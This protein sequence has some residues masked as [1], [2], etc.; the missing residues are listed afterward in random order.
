MTDFAPDL[1]RKLG[2]GPIGAPQRPDGTAPRMPRNGIAPPL[3]VPVEV[4]EQ[5]R[6]PKRL[7]VVTTRGRTK[8]GRP[9]VMMV[10]APGFAIARVIMT[11]LDPVTKQ[12]KVAVICERRR[13][14]PANSQRG[15]NGGES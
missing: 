7:K 1:A 3:Q 9:F 11:D 4:R 6:K 15:E 2:Q 12:C 8:D 14:R 5:S 10:A 13:G